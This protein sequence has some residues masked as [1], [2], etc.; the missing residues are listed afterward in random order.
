MLATKSPALG[1]LYRFFTVT[2]FAVTAVTTSADV[3]KPTPTQIQKTSDCAKLITATRL[4]LEQKGYLRGRYGI[5]TDQL[6][7]TPGLQIPVLLKMSG[8]ETLAPA[9]LAGPIVRDQKKYDAVI[10]GSG[11]AGLTMALFLAKAGWS[12]LVLE[13]NPE[14]GG[15]GMGSTVMG[16]EFGGGAAYST[17]FEKKGLQHEIAK[18]I[19]L[20][21]FERH[22]AIHEPIDS[23]LWKGKLYRGIWEE[24]ALHDL[25]ASFELFKHALLKL[26]DMGAGGTQGAKAKWADGMYMDQMVR[27]MP[28]MVARWSDDE[29]KRIMDRFNKDKDLNRRDPMKEVL[30]LLDNYGRSALGF[31]ADQVPAR[32]FINFYIS[33]IFRRYTGGLGTG[34][35]MQAT[36]NTIKQQY[37]G[38]VDFKTSAPVV[39][40]EN[41]GGGTRTV[42]IENGQMHEVFSDYST[43]AVPVTLA[44]KLVKGLAQIDPA[45]TTAIAKIRDT[46]YSVQ[47]FHVQ[48]HPYRATYDT[49]PDNNGNNSLPSDFIL[50]RW[51]D[52]AVDGYH[53]MRDFSSNPRDDYGGIT[54][55]HPLGYH[56]ASNSDVDQRLRIVDVD[57]TAMA[58]N[59]GP[60]ISQ[61]RQTLKVDFVESYIWPSSIQL[62][63]LNSLEIMPDLARPIDRIHFAHNSLSAPEL[64]PTMEIGAREAQALINDRAASAHPR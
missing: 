14:L 48:G 33:E 9:P 59:L 55:Y 17:G 10:V 61:D 7:L 54:A 15:L 36:I 21:D 64:E 11:A 24:T 57:M 44:P 40:T 19:G 23:F 46:D 43:L 51:M 16:Y 53:G 39:S 32:H 30:S 31:T 1:F 35:I 42:Y 2:V 49:W 56:N 20:D 50:P 3:L 26:D 63:P 25:P 13:R 47:I 4:N 28:K 62:M 22:L 34:T 27:Q 8:S 58:K 37:P 29:S 52:P 5:D 6:Q 12:V 41:I 18:E 60:L 38:C 45:K